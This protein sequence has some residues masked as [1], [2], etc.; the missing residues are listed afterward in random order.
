MADL[1]ALADAIST[2]SPNIR[3]FAEAVADVLQ[4]PTPPPAS[5]VWAWDA[6]TAT[7]SPNSA[8][9]VPRAAI[10]AQNGAY[11]AA[12]V[13][14]N[15]ALAGTPAYF[16][17][18]G[19]WSGLDPRVPVPYGTLHG[20]TDDAHLFVLDTLGREHDLWAAVYDAS[21]HLISSAGGGSSFPRDAASEPTPGMANAARF[22]LSRG[23]IRPSDFHGGSIDHPLVMTV[24]L[25]A[26]HGPPCVYPANTDWNDP[27]VP[28]G[29]WYRLDPAY[30]PDPSFDTATLLICRALQRYGAFVRDESGLNNNTVAF[31]AT[32]EVNQGGNAT[33]PVPLPIV[34][35]AG[36]PYAAKL[37]AI[38]WNRLQALAP[39]T[40]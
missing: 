25:A 34:N 35:K 10:P 7:V 28:Y 24:P 2:K 33:W 4:P 29:Q 11:L 3:A 19:Q 20:A 21:S 22:P 30:A 37:G 5:S 15:V 23:L 9:L 31:F 8:Q 27:V 18:A 6:R 38:P 32:D 39:P 1:H 36:Y 13:A 40:P 14:Y 12:T 26:V 16:I 17:P